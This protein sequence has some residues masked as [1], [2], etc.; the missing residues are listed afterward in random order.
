MAG[1]EDID[2]EKMSPEAMQAIIDADPRVVA[3]KLKIAEEAADYWKSI[4]PVDSG[5]Y[6]DSIK[7]HQ[8]GTDVWVEASDP[9]APFI[10]YGTKDTPEFAPRQKT[11]EHFATR[12]ITIE[13]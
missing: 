10:E 6:R 13:L 11:D 12:D 5:A 8:N 7:A 2:L 4:S 3:A 1:L 9:A